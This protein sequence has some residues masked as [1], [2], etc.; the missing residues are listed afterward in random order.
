M[1]DGLATVDILPNAQIAVQAGDQQM[2]APGCAT[3]AG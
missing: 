2:H 3:N 1:S